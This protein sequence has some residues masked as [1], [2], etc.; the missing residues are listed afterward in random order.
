MSEPRR[1]RRIL[2]GLRTALRAQR[3][4]TIGP[5]LSHRRTLVAQILKTQAVRQAVRRGDAGTRRTEPSGE[6]AG[7]AAGWRAGMR[8]RSPP[9]IRSP[10]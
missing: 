8:W 2:R 10:S 4:S 1:V 5:D 6:A 9:I 7:G 3:T